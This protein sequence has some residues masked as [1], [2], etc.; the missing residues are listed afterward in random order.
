MR[1]WMVGAMLVLAACSGTPDRTH[2]QTQ[3]G[4]RGLFIADAAVSPSGGPRTLSLLVNTQT[5]PAK[6]ELL[7]VELLGPDGSVVLRSNQA[8]D[9]SGLIRFSLDQQITQQPGLAAAIDRASRV[10]IAGSE[11]RACTATLATP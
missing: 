11:G 4:C 5:R 2:V 7:E 1:H 8:T 10:K 3:S 9:S 6:G